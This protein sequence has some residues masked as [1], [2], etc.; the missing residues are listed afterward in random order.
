MQFRTERTF[1]LD[2]LDLQAV[3]VQEVAEVTFLC[4]GVLYGKETVVETYFRLKRGVAL[5]PIDGGFGFAVSSF[6]TGFGVGIVRCINGGDVS[7]RI[8]LASGSLNDVRGFETYFTSARGETI[9]F[10]IGVFQEVSALDPEF[11][12]E[13][14]LTGAEFRV[15]VNVLCDEGF[16]FALIIGDDE[17]NG[18]K[19]SAYAR[20]CLFEVLADGVLKQTL[21]DHA[22]HFGVTDLI[23]EGTNRLRRVSATAETTDGRHTRIIPASNKTFLDKLEH[24]A[25]R[26]HG[27]SDVE[28]VE[29]TL[30]R[31]IVRS[32]RRET[33]EVRTAE[34]VDEIVVQRTV[35]LKLQR[36]DRVRHSFEIVRLSVREVV[37]RIDVPF[38][39]CAVVRMR[40]DDAVHDRVAEVHIR[41]RHVNFRT[42]Y[43]FAFF[44]LA[45]LHRFEELQVLFNRTIA[46]RRSHTRF[47]RCTFLLGDLLCCLLID[48]GFSLFDEADSEVV[49]LLE[50]V[51]G[52]ED[53]SPFET[54]PA[55]VALDGLYVFG[56]LFSR[57]GIVETQVTNAVVFLSDTEIH[58]DCLDVA[59]MQ[60]SVRL[61]RET[62]LNTSAIYSLSEVFFYDLLNKIEAPSLRLILTF[63]HFHI[64][65]FLIYYYLTIPRAEFLTKL[66]IRSRSTLCGISAM[67]FSIACVV[68]KP[69]LLMMRYTSWIVWICSAV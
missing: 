4:R 22:F 2:G 48:I 62:R 42:E 69:L 35:Y 15:T 66:T 21:V 45:A 58:A 34:L 47:G 31:A 53:L 46:V 37:H 64:C 20:S 29:L 19:Y 49:E 25:L 43:H 17:F 38:A 6:G 27:I 41:V 65:T 60:V 14:H 7:F 12:S 67:I 33:A 32:V 13:L 18:I 63:T 10:I 57:V 50:I 36:T 26:H 24:F 30:F 39:S 40:G 54:E 23:H 11:A 56:V 5:Y 51:G 68:F 59:D 9:E 44:Y 16:A 8:L 61:R 3:G 1:D 28:A 55:D 52:I